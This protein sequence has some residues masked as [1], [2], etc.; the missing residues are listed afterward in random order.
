MNEQLFQEVPLSAPTKLRLVG[1]VNPPVVSMPSI[2]TSQFT[3]PIASSL[4]QSSVQAIQ[5]MDIDIQARWANVSALKKSYPGTPPPANWG[6]LGFN[7]STSV[8]QDSQARY[9]NSLISLGRMLNQKLL[10][11]RMHLTYL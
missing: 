10:M 6:S 1:A 11:S 2:T 5:D 8:V 9:H 7:A 4:P 3:V